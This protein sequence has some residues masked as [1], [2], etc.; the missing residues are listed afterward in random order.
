MVLL[1]LEDHYGQYR[2]EAQESMSPRPQTGVYAL[3]IKLPMQ[4]TIRIGR[5]GPVSSG[6]G[7]YVYIGSALNSFEGRISRHFRI[8]KKK[9]WHVDF[10]IGYSGVR[11]LG[12]A[13]RPTSKKLECAMSRAVQER[14]LS[15]V[16]R[17]GCSDCNCDS[18]LHYVRTPQRAHKVLSEAGFVCTPTH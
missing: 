7:V 18:H 12:V 1:L 10:L 14:A 11:L 6:R 16:S 15:S 9:H 8:E 17:F 13:T 5:L 3:L 4:K 2:E